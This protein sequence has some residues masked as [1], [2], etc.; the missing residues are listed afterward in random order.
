MEGDGR[1]FFMADALRSFAR[2]GAK[3]RGKNYRMAPRPEV[4]PGCKTTANHRE[5]NR[6][7]ELP[8]GS[9]FRRTRFWG[10]EGGCRRIALPLTRIQIRLEAALEGFPCTMDERLGGLQGSSQDCSDLLVAQFAVAAEDER[11][12]L[13]LGQRGQSLVHEVE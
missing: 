12:S 13:F 10:T 1:D 8:A 11:G 6:E 5:T 2:V 7:T 3:S 9:A 4:S